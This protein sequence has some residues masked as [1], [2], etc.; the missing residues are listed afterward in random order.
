MC[1][2]KDPARRG[3]PG[4]RADSTSVAEDS[5][6]AAATQCGRESHFGT[7]THNALD[8]LLESMWVARGIHGQ[9]LDMQAWVK[10]VMLT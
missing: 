6:D 3:L 5:S 7:P 2:I 10:S 9:T 1:C 8:A 4:L